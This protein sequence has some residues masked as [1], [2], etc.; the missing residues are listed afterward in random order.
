[1]DKD[2]A[3]NDVTV[4]PGCD[5]IIATTPVKVPFDSYLACP[6]CKYKVLN[7]KKDTLNRTLALSLTG[8]FLFIPAHF[9]LLLQLEALG[10]IDQGTVIDS[11]TAVYTQRYFFVSLMVLITA[12]LIPFIKL[13]LLFIVSYSLEKRLFF[14]KLPALFRWYCHIEE[15]GM[16]EVFLIGIL[17]T[18]IKMNHTADIS[19]GVGFFSFVGLS[20]A[21]V[22]SVFTLDKHHYWLMIE[23]LKRAEKNIAAKKI[24]QSLYVRPMQLA[25]N[26]G[27]V[28]CHTCHKVIRYEEP[29]PGHVLQCPRCDGIVHKRIPN[30][31]ST[32][33]ALV[34]TAVFFSFPANL[35]PIMQ[36]DFLGTPQKTT[37]MDGIIYFFQSGSLGIGL[38]ILTASILV[39][40]F[41]VVGLAILLYSIHFNRWSRLTQK[42]LMFRFVEFVGRWSMLDIFVIALLCALV[43]FGF[44][45]R[46]IPAPAATFF[47][48]VVLSTMFAAISFDPR[49]LWDITSPKNEGNKE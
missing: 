30:S 14:R 29:E 27:L 3:I 44:F 20:L 49:I 41:K 37:I 33:F 19:F 23:S 31:L 26:G 16:T 40:V 22:G 47:T 32:T 6:R 36:V 24:S 28:Q 43:D 13:L 9:M 38:V 45:T 7:P 15:W 25:L 18:I 1:M 12:I 21:L 11:M 8:L 17:I 34:L 4:C 39:P 5:M 10:F 48:F 46:I 35:L 42:S 2:I